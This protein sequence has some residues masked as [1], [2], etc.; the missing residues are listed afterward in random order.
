MSLTSELHN[1][2]SAINRW[3]DGHMNLESMS[4]LVSRVNRLLAKKRILAAS[5]DVNP[6]TMGTAF[7]YA[8]R[9]QVE[10]LVATRLV[11]L[12]GARILHRPEWIQDLVQIGNDTPDRRPACCVA[13]AWFE[14]VYR[15]DAHIPNLETAESPTRLLDFVTPFEVADIHALTQSILVVWGDRLKGLYVPNPTFDGSKDVGGADADWILGGALYDCKCSWKRRPFTLD[16]LKQVLGYLFLD[17][18]NRYNLTSF[19]FYFPRHQLRLE[20]DIETFMPDFR[21]R[22][23]SFIDGVK[24]DGRDDEFDNGDFNSWQEEMLDIEDYLSHS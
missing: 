1:P 15:H 7:D 16:H 6:A 12:H 21:E 4:K 22:Q 5:N 9:W 20:W 17:Y 19:G 8:F 11:A 23:E 18:S 2:N 13:L 10:S 24:P 14:Q 3:F